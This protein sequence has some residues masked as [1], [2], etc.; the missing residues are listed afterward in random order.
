L[1][2]SEEENVVAADPHFVDFRRLFFHY[3]G[4]FALPLPVADDH[5]FTDAE[6]FHNPP[7][8]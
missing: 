1:Y 3:S 4:R 6:R 5:H 7:P 8:Q 2:K